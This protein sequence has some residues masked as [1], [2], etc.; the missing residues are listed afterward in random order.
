MSR[1]A[2]VGRPRDRLKTVKIPVEDWV[3][4]DKYCGDEKTLHDGL[5]EIVQDHRE[6]SEWAKDED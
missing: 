6:F 2:K 1:K 3:Y 5:H 4:L